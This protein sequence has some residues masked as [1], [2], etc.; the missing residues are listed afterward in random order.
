ML[1]TIISNTSKP[2]NLEA[3]RI[4]VIPVKCLVGGSSLYKVMFSLL[5]VNLLPDAEGSTC[6]S[7]GFGGPWV[8]DW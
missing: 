7:A 8:E 6:S 4:H 3:A 1:Q 2:P 5:P